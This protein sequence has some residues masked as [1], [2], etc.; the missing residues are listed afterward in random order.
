MRKIQLKNQKTDEMPFTGERYLPTVEAAQINY[1]HWHRYLYVTNFVNNKKVLDIACG[2]GYGS[3]LLSIYAEEV[4]G[5]DISKEAIE[6]AS[7]KYIKKNLQFISG[8]AT[9]IPVKE[10]AVFDTVVSFETIEHLPE[11][12]Q[13]Y[14]LKE[15]K[16]VLK[17][18]GVLIVSTPNR[19]TYSEIPKYRNEYHIKEFYIAEF[20]EFLNNLFKNV[21]IL[22]QKVY[23]LSYIWD[24]LDSGMGFKEY[25]IEQSKSGFQPTHNPKDPLYVLAF[26]SDAEIK[27]LETSVLV[28]LSEALI[29]EKNREIKGLKK[30]TSWKITAPLR[31]LNKISKNK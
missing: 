13:K 4:I 23:A 21:R 3:N 5:I 8:T 29:A 12:D 31:W 27:N 9:D 2:E 22:G 24:L 16:R 17:P 25:R 15:V 10:S 6:R 18:E 14:F 7:S 1:E 20:N 19:L 26:C 28:D 11:P 30:S